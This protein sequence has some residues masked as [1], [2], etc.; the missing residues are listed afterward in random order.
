[1]A[2]PDPY[3]VD[4]TMLARIE[5]RETAFGAH[6]V[7]VYLRAGMSGGDFAGLLRQLADGFDKGDLTRVDRPDPKRN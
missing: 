2:D 7:Q 3:D 1:M 6:Q 5:I 4:P